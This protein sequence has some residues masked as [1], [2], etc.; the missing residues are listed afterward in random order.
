MWLKFSLKKLAI[1]LVLTNLIGFFGWCTTLQAVVT[2]DPLQDKEA[3]VFFKVVKVR[4]GDVLNIRSSPNP[5]SKKIGKI[6]V[7]KHCIAYLNEMGGPTKTWVKIAY[8]GVK[9]WASLNYLSQE[10]KSCGTY[11]KVI[12]VRSHLNIRRSP[13]LYS[14]RLGKIPANEEC[15]LGI[16]KYVSR[17]NRKWAMV[18]YSGVK[19]WVNAKYLKEIDVDEC[20]V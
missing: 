3:V 13:F 15:F 18:R 4:A 14:K 2:Y 8:K 7:G 20:D 1:V 10:E 11:Y 5:R 19:G 16:D 12:N 17:L 9:G 6:P